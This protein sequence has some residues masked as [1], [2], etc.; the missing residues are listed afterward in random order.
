MNASCQ[1]YECIM[2]RRQGVH[3]GWGHRGS[4]GFRHVQAPP[5]TNRGVAWLAHTCV[6][7]L[8]HLYVLI[9]ICDIICDMINLYAYDMT[10]AHVRDVTN[11]SLYHK[12]FICG[13]HDFW[14]FLM[15]ATKHSS[16]YLWH[17]FFWFVKWLI[18]THD[19]TYFYAWHA[20]FISAPCLI[21]ICNTIYSCLRHDS[22]QKLTLVFACFFLLFVSLFVSLFLSYDCLCFRSRFLSLAL[23][24][25]HSRSLFLCPPHLHHTHAHSLSSSHTL[26]CSISLSNSFSLSLSREIRFKASLPTKTSLK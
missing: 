23:F 2:S 3:V 25:S 22:C 17:D 20:A 21:N 14:L 1:T 7:C 16:W 12:S 11:S 4:A 9:R 5:T 13:W 15:C 10:H 6:T 8:I 18:H 19:M 24:F 26:L